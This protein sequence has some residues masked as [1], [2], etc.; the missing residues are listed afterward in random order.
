MLRGGGPAPLRFLCQVF[1]IVAFET[2]LLSPTKKKR[3]KFDTLCSTDAAARDRVLSA[4]PH[5]AQC[6]R[7]PTATF[8]LQS[9][10]Q[11]DVSFR[12]DCQPSSH[13]TKHTT[14]VCWTQRAGVPSELS[15]SIRHL[16]SHN[17]TSAGREP[18]NSRLLPWI[19]WR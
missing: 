10:T 6:G 3:H 4:L 11:T 12:S 19:H 1:P 16:D 17:N 5:T 7:A 15:C 13:S 2:R 9:V 14:V 8:A 18:Q